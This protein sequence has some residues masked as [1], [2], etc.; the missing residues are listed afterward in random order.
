ME[1]S[2]NQNNTPHVESQRLKLREVIEQEV[3]VTKNK[4][5]SVNPN[6]ADASWLFDFR[7][8]LLRAEVLDCIGELF[9]EKCKNEYPFQVGG[10]EVAAIPLITGFALKMREKRAPANGFFIRKSRK[11]SGL[12]RMIEG[13]LTDEK[14]ILVDDTI[15]TGKS[16]IRQVEVIE[17]LGKKVSAVFAVLR[18]RDESYYDYFHKKNIRIFSLF[19]LDD[20]KDSLNVKNL[21]DREQKPVPMPFRP[22]WYW[23]AEKPDYFH[24]IPKSAPT[25]DDT[26]IY[27][28][29][30]NGSFWA[31]NQS[32][33]STVWEYKTLLASRK[34]KV[35]SS[36]ALY[37]E[38][39]YFGAHDG[40]LYALDKNT[41]KRKWVF[42][43]A[44]WIRSS[45][46]V[47]PDLGLVFVGLEFG[48]WK[49][50]GGV[51]ALDADTGKKK[52]EYSL[53]DFVHSSPAYSRKF[54]VVVC[55]CNDFSAYAFN[56]KTGALLWSFKTDREINESFALDEERGL[57]CFGSL[58]SHLYVLKTKT[59]ELVHKI[60]TDGW[61]YATPLISNHFVYAASL[62]KSLY[63]IDLN[64]GVVVWKFA[65]RGR[66][67]AS[68]EII[69]NKI[70]IGSNDGRLYELD[71]ET[72][73]NTAFFQ[74][75]ERITDK[76]ACNK[77]TGN[78]FLPTFANE[79]YCLSKK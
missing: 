31:L 51:M 1:E 61:M 19:A 67:F 58:D 23:K 64:T 57:V 68:P 75:T 74:A 18:Y 50:R 28:G 22:Q 66:I 47:A 59:G 29:T 72:G 35:F 45:P 54:G 62:D 43:E 42:M 37:K 21:V 70:Y 14:V 26:K 27:F 8:V 3:F 25:I 15:N 49:K 52:W 44:D 65:T 2:S 20:F 41:G 78:I 17:S 9:W 24:V 40:N 56:A 4:E 16:F 10:I 5:R 77:K 38:F 53:T 36:A 46:C 48:L 79:I 39:I 6:G 60:Q 13:E 63:C 12:L 73:E 7:R 34:R 11:K 30:D 71:A 33:G 76:I 69:G 32:D 55:G